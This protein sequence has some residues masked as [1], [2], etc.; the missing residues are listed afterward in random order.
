ML[1]RTNLDEEIYDILLRNILEG[2]YALGE[3]IRVEDLGK[4]LGVSCTPVLTALR[5][6]EYDGLITS[7]TRSGFYMPTY[8]KTVVDDISNALSM[9]YFSAFSDIIDNND[10]AYIDKLEEFARLAEKAYQNK[11]FEEYT[12]RDRDFHRAIVDYLH[13]D[14]LLE[15]YNRLHHQVAI[16]Q[17][18]NSPS[19]ERGIGRMHPESHFLWCELLRKK[20]LFALKNALKNYSKEINE[21]PGELY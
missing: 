2:K 7:R 8:D 12:L 20:D 18:I 5:R 19:K 17:Q 6:L 3:K 11:N 13:N 16:Y 10:S 9:V 4:E 15:F 21:H 14:H 1:K